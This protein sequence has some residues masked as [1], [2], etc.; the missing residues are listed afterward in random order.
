MILDSCFLIDLLDSEAAA[1]AKLEEIDDELLVV[2]TLVYTEVAVGI[3]PETST[4]ERFEAIMD[5]VPLVA[6]DGEAARRAVDVQRDLQAAGER[7][8][9]IDA[10]I[11]GIALARD[12]S[13]VTRNAGEFARTPVRVSPY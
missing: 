5:D 9:A 7:I 1:V 2:P 10:M 13:V 3:G 4:G 6:Y 8:G 11:A 12:E